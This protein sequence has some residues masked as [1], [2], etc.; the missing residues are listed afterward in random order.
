MFGRLGVR[1]AGSVGVVAFGAGAPRVLPPR[2]AK[3]GLVALRRM[4]AAGRRAR[5]PAAIPTPWPTR[6]ASGAAGPPAGA[7]RRD[8]A[9]SATSTAGSGRSAS[10]RVRHSVLA[11][12][13]VDPREA[14]LPAV[15]HLALVDPESGAPRRGRHLEPPRARAVRGARARAARRARARAAPA[16]HR[17]RHAVHRRGLAAGARAPPAMSFASPLWLLALALIPIAIAACDRCARRRA[18]RYAVRFTAVSTLVLAAGAATVVAAPPAGRVRAR[19]DRR[20][21]ARARPPAH[22]LQRPHRPGIADARHRP[23]GFDGR[24]RRAADAARRR[25]QGREHVHRPAAGQCPRRR[26]RVLERAGRR[27]GAGREPLCARAR[28]STSRSRT[29]RPTRA[30]RCSS[31]SSCSDGADKKHPPSAIVLLSDGAANAGVDP[32]DGG[33]AGGAGQDPDLHGRARNPERRPA[34]PG[35]VRNRRSPSRPTRS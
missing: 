32:F 26:D 13:I 3:P 34:E 4:L 9:T 19:G 24:D 15:G 12:E 30:T 16:A 22:E 27:A 17:P 8:L 21:R 18:R 11:V 23:L 29:A 31:R 35:P 7:R 28:S 1:R 6:C 33:P 14:E 5:R 2:G 10:L 20:A 25:R